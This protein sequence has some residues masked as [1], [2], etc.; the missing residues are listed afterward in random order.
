MSSRHDELRDELLVIL[1][2]GRELSP[3]ADKQLAEAFIRFLE[4]ERAPESRKARPDQACEQPHYSLQIAGGIWG[5]ALTFLV[6][7]LI[8]GHP[9]FA[10]FI[11][12][13]AIVL[14]LA[15]VL[16]SALLYLARNDWHVPQVR[17]SVSRQ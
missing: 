17:V 6:L 4:Q 15:A 8:I 14:V 5:V 12:P 13:A 7:A 16:S 9:T 11:G 2:A 1:G 10:Q 3:E